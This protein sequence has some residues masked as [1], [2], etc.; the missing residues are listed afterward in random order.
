MAELTA[1]ANTVGGRSVQPVNTFDSFDPFTGRPW[2]TIPASTREDVDDAVAAARAAFQS[3]EWAGLTP[4]GRGKLLVR[5]AELIE[6]EAN[7]L[8][9]IETR[10]NGKLIAEMSAQL[11]Y[12][13]EWF[14]Y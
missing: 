7:R 9:A 14:R 11:H 4:T 8:A 10:D 2:A 1:F 13:P 5:V 3:R 6:A 12:I